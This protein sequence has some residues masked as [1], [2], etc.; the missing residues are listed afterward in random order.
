MGGTQVG[1]IGWWS[2]LLAA[3]LSSWLLGVNVAGAWDGFWC[4]HR[5]ALLRLVAK[6]SNVGAHVDVLACRLCYPMDCG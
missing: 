4:G 1:N 3:R 6:P 2:S 5:L